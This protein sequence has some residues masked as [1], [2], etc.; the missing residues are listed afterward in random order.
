MCVNLFVLDY[1]QKEIEE[2]IDQYSISCPAGSANAA[3]E[4]NLVHWP[5]IKCWWEVEASTTHNSPGQ[6]KDEKTCQHCQ[7][8]VGISWDSL[9]PFGKHFSHCMAYLL[10]SPNY[11]F[12]FFN[13]WSL[14]D[15]FWCFWLNIQHIWPSSN[16]LY[17][18]SSCLIG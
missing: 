3:W 7:H 12:F 11:V 1:P 8:S 18:S 13:S 9:E 6:W 16:M 15:N 5:E 14:F 10:L 17:P 2:E 4:P